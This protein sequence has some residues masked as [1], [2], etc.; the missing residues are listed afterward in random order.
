LKETAM[1]DRTIFCLGGGGRDGN[2]TGDL[3][4]FFLDPAEEHGHGMLFLDALRECVDDLAFRGEPSLRVTR[5]V[6]IASGSRIDLLIESGTSVLAIETRHWSG[7]RHSLDDVERFAREAAARKPD[8]SLDLVVLG[9]LP[10][11]VSAP[12]RFVSYAALISALRS[13]L[14]TEYLRT[15]DERWRV[16]TGEFLR[17]LAVQSGDYDDAELASMLA[18]LRNEDGRLDARRSQELGAKLSPFVSARLAAALGEGCVRTDAWCEAD[19]GHGWRWNNA[20]DFQ[21]LDKKASDVFVSLAVRHSVA[22]VLSGAQLYLVAWVRPH[23]RRPDVAERCRKRLAGVGFEEICV[24]GV[25]HW[26]SGGAYDRAMGDA[27]LIEA[28]AETTSV[29]RDIRAITEGWSN[30]SDPLPSRH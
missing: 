1:S 28:I 13:R 26:E 12:W 14:T 21:V 16:L 30:P 3:L 20:I 5:D 10:E 27:T 8:G 18:A 25:R 4:R 2:A 23:A 24:P 17:H 9:V 6:R 19:V 22:E 29:V 11:A 7:I 15:V